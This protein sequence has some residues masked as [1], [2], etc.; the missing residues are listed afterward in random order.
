MLFRIPDNGR[1]V[2]VGAL[3]GACADVFGPLNAGRFR[4]FGCSYVLVC[5]D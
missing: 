3:E 1:P 5:P 2:Y 4:I